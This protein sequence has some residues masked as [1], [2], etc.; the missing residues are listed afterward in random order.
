MRKTIVAILSAVVAMTSCTKSVETKKNQ[1]NSDVFD[2]WLYING[3]DSC[4]ALVD[5]LRIYILDEKVGTGAPVGT[6]SQHPFAR[7]EYNLYDLEGNV[8]TTSSAEVAK[9]LGNYNDDATYYGPYVWSRADNGLY[10]GV[11]Y[12]LE[13]MKVG[14]E[15][16]CAIPGWYMSN[17][18]YGSDAEYMAN[19]EGTDYI[20]EIKVKDVIDDIKAWELDSL[21]TFLKA[22]YPKAEEIDTTG[23]YLMRLEPPFNSK[24]TL[25]VGKSYNINYIGRLL[26]GQVFDTNVKDTAVFYGLTPSNSGKPTY[27]THAASAADIK[28]GSE[29]SSVIT[30]FALGLQNLKPGEKG[31]VMFVS[32][33]GY[34]TSGSSTVIPGYCPLVFDIENLGIKE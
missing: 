27:F 28:F 5:G 14:G 22:N 34:G 3:Y 20:Y 2:S 18:R 24:D 9:R 13:H 32:S 26:N 21:K 23:A 7:V 25:V 29:S 1:T 30:G 19:A 16:K 15:L 4:P 10:A 12:M 33:L 8:I 31:R 17:T 11:E 6:A